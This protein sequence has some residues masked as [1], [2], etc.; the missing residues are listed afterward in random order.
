MTIR[1]LAERLTALADEAA[2]SEETRPSAGVL[3][4]LLAAIYTD[5]QAVL[6]LLNHTAALSTAELRGLQSG[7]N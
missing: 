2:Q 6:R 7:R 4:S 1:E 5:D 3:Y